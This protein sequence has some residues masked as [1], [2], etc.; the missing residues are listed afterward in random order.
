MGKAWVRWGAELFP[1][2]EPISPV[3]LWKENHGVHSVSA[4]ELS[5]VCHLLLNE[6]FVSP[7]MGSEK[8]TCVYVQGRII[9]LT[10]QMRRLRSREAP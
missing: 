3:F 8:R 5:E 10:L 2:E 1:Y 7:Q 4:L 9:Y 6:Q